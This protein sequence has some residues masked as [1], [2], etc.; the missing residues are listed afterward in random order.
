M[1]QPKSTCNPSHGCVPRTTSLDHHRITEHHAMN[2]RTVLTLPLSLIASARATRRHPSGRLAVS[3]L[4]LVVSAVAAG[5]VR[6]RTGAAVEIAVEGRASSNA[7][8]AASGSLV[9]VTWAA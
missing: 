1:L 9:G 4:V 8:I 3:G 7:S 2:G 6:T 5:P